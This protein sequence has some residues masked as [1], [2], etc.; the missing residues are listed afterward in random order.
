MKKTSL[1]V[2][3]QRDRAQVMFL[4]TTQQQARTHAWS[5]TPGGRRAHASSI[6]EEGL[7]VKS[8][9]ISAPPRAG[10]TGTVM[11]LLK[12]SFFQ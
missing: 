10:T 2:A 4:D 6:D 7:I 8:K 1:G 3:L 9:A 11:F 5:I 12:Y